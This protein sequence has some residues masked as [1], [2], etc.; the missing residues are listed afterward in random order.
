VAP[1]DFGERKA[2]R[3]W[4]HRDR[5]RELEIAGAARVNKMFVYEKGA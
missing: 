5:C 2:F 1:D 3:E 4:T